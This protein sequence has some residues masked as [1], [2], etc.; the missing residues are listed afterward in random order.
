MPVET[1]L[2]LGAA[3]D[4][5]GGL[6]WRDLRQSMRHTKRWYIDRYKGALIL[7]RCRRFSSA[8]IRAI[9]RTTV[10]CVSINQANPD[11]AATAHLKRYMAFVSFR[12]LLYR[13]S[14]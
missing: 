1:D 8:D 13:S 7:T 3:S 6:I 10:G 12:S 11:L 4:N 5:D 2:V 14:R 9:S